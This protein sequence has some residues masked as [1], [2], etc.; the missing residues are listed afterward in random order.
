MMKDAS[1]EPDV[2]NCNLEIIWKVGAPES[3]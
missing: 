1:G 3:S 2:I